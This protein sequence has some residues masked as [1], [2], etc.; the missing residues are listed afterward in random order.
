MMTAVESNSSSKRRRR[1][2]IREF[3]LNTSTHA[4]PGVARSTS[5]HNRL[6]WSISFVCASGVMLYLIIQAIQAYLA[7]PTQIGLNIV[8]EW[9]QYF[10]AF[11]FCNAGFL[12]FDLFIQSFVNYT[13][14]FNLTNTND[15]STL[16]PSQA[17]YISRFILS[18][19]NSNQ[20]LQPFFYSLSS[21][22]YKCS[23]NNQPC[24][25]SD[26]IAFTTSA[27]GSCYTFNARLTNTS[28]DSIRYGNQNGSNGKLELGLYVHSHQYVPYLSD[29]ESHLCRSYGWV[30]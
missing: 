14:A 27:Y 19:L 21:M 25:T 26:F 24:S 13:N 1:S 20:S 4:L 30:I 9:P 15:T 7:Y 6:F 16:S 2:I 12:R 10:P 18:Q 5:W 3:C 17:N 29:G 23:Y 22:L 11:S 8:N 28:P